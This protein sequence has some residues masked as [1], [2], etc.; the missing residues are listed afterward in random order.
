MTLPVAPRSSVRVGDRDRERTAALLGTG[1]AHGYLQLADYEQRLQAA[2]AAE[3][4][5]ALRAVTAD[6]PVRTL[7]RNDPARRAARR[8]AATRAVRIHL[9]GYLGMVAIVLTVWLAV[10]VTADAWYFWPVWPMLGGAIGL[11]SHAT[12]VRSGRGALNLLGCGAVT[13]PGRP[14]V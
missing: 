6:L 9:A 12:S 2:F 10:A 4:D 1:L 3:T 11:I 8:A 7:Q 13:R 5:A 14:R